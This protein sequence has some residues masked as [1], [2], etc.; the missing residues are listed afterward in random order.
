M[1]SLEQKLEQINPQA[2]YTVPYFAKLAGVHPITVYQSLSGIK[3]FPVPAA[4]RI[5]RAIRFKGQ[6]LLD[7]FGG[8]CSVKVPA[9]AKPKSAVGKRRGRPTKAEQIENALATGGAV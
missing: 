5:G 9:L 8:L 6:A 2:L 4:V 1:F 7:Y 3:S